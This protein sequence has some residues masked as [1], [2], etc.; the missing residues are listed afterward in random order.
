MSAPQLIQQFVDQLQQTTPLETIAVVAGMASVVLANRNNV[1]LYPTG[2]ISTI[3]Y[4]YIL[5]RPEAGLYAE[6]ALNVY[7]L[8]MSIY[9]WVLWIR[10]HENNNPRAITRSTRKEWTITA[11]IVVVGW[12]LLYT[13]LKTY[14]DS[15]VPVW[16]A[17]VSCTAW[18]G[19]WLL[20]KHK[21]E[22]WILLNISNALA[23][24]LFLYKGMPLTALLT[25]FLFIV[26]VSGYFNWRKA[27][28]TQSTTA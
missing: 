14:T 26:A 9:G 6:T 25:L 5:S 10:G 15:T 8:V 23:I 18:A 21:I 4:I 2:I 7:Y 28:R 20:A 1:W 17:I 19:M 22:N 3:I 16:D 27:M 12:G 13:V 24:P 11:G